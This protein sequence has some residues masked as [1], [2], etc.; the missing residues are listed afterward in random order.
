MLCYEGP[1]TIEFRFLR[2]TFNFTKVYTWLL[3]FNA[4]LKT[5]EEWTTKYGALGVRSA[6]KVCCKELNLDSL[7]KITVEEIV[8]MLLIKM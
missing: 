2:P 5:A 4:I 3:V 8:N 7:D 1:K 6:C